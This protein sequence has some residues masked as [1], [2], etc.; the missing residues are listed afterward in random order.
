MTRVSDDKELEQIVRETVQG[1]RVLLFPP[2]L[3]SFVMTNML[4][5]LSVSAFVL[6]LLDIAMAER[7]V[8]SRAIGQ[9]VFVVFATGLL[10]FPAF[11]VI[12]GN[13]RGMT[14]LRVLATG[15]TLAAAFACLVS[16][17]QFLPLHLSG[18]ALAVASGSGALLLL[19]TPGYSLLARFYQLRA[20]M[21][22]ERRAIERG[23]RVP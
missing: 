22:K 21:M 19:A 8:G 18:P 11:L 17:W 10:V 13:N 12:R 5:L 1:K 2:G 23:G 9:L 3:F 20:A 7:S 14:L 16:W 4:L 6:P 15:I